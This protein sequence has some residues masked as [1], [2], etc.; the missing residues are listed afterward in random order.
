MSLRYDV[1]IIGAGNAGLTAACRASIMGLKCLVIEKNNTVGGAAASFV[2]GRFEFEASLHEI[3][4]FGPG[5]HKGILGHLFDELG[6]KMEW[7]G[8]PDA[9]RYIVAEVG[10]ESKHLMD[11]TVPHGRDEFTEYM[12]SQVPGS[13][14]SVRLF[15][16][17]ADLVNNCV[18]Y[19][20]KSRGKPDPQLLNTEHAEAMKIMSLG[21]G[22]FF[23]TI[24]MPQKAIDIISAYWPYQGSD[25]ET[26]DASR[27]LL[28]ADSYFSGGAY[29]P[30]MRSH[31]IANELEKVARKKGCDFWYNTE[32]TKILT[33]DGAVCGA[34]TSNGLSV[35]ACAVISNAFPDT[36]YDKLLDNK[37]LIPEY[38]LKKA[39]AR[40][41]GF[42]AF[43]LYL[44]LDA[45]PEEL[46]IKDYTVFMYPST[47][48]QEIFNL[49][50]EDDLSGEMLALNLTATCINIINPDATPPGTSHF[51]LTSAYVTNIWDT[52]SPAEYNKIKHR[53]ANAMLDR[54]E[55]VMGID[56][57]SHIEEVSI[58]SPVTFARYLGT[59]QGSV[60]GYHSSTWDGMSARTLAGGGELTVP[61][62]FFVGAHGNRLSGFLPT[63]TGGDIT[64]RQVMGYVMSG[65]ESHGQSGPPKVGNLGGPPKGAGPGGPGKL[66]GPPQGAG[67]GGSGRQQGAGGERS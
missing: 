57:R 56:I 40:E 9:Y 61:G 2:R 62:L 45:S 46:G 22:E 30:K 34:E 59:P 8:I 29:M 50:R 49:V 44:G 35:E 65:G 37:S 48:T 54:Y 63:L 31:E 55:K 51:A 43:V 33:K 24:K 12:E 21:T 25:I 16:E 13:T 64:A 67:P 53:V 23:R 39:N 60:Y 6:I 11:F 15:F 52:V 1:V 36:V 19:L 28:M 3:P 47:D 42:R 10:N 26:I 66:G 38:E 4:D 20:G 58:A 18:E 14:P 5:E 17:A 7:L 32:V 27:Y 41:F